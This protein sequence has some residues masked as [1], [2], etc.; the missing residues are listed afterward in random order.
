MCLQ[1]TVLYSFIRDAMQPGVSTAVQIIP[2]CFSFFSLIF[3]NENIILNPHYN[4]S[5][6]MYIFSGEQ[7]E[8]PGS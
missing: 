3:T 6:Q 2:G 1:Q 7:T 8:D 5:L 4:T